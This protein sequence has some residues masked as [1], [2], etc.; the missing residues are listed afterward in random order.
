LSKDLP[1]TAPDFAQSM[2]EFH[3]Q[4]FG[5][6]M[7]LTGHLDAANDILQETNVV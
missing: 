5:Y 1:A 7:T 6:V 4:L 3:G 2:T